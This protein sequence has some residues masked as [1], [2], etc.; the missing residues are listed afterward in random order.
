MKWFQRNGRYLSSPYQLISSI[1]G[2]E[3]WI[4]TAERFVC[5]GRELSLD[6]AKNLCLKHSLEAEDVKS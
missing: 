4:K 6:D 1:R 5:L 2:Y 3:A